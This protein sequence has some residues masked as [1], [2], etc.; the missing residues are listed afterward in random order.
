MKQYLKIFL[1]FF[2]LG[3]LTIIAKYGYVGRLSN[4]GVSEEQQYVSHALS[5]STMNGSVPDKDHVLILFR[6]GI[7]EKGI[8]FFYPF[9]QQSPFGYERPVDLSEAHAGH[10][11]YVLL[12]SHLLALPPEFLSS[13]SFRSPPIP[14]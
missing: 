1:L 11:K 10:I 12:F 5:V 7:D 2:S 14:C 4:S 3:T 6:K 9:S 8:L 13:S